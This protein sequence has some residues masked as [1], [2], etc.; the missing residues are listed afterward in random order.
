MDTKHVVLMT[1][2][3]PP[4]P[5]FKEQ[6]VYSW[7]ILLGLTRTV[8]PIPKSLIPLIAL[9]RAHGRRRM[10]RDHGYGSPLEALTRLQAARLQGALE[11]LD[12]EATWSAKVAFEFRLSRLHGHDLR[13]LSLGVLVKQHGAEI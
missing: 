3:E 11:A 12:R 1:Y 13:A 2:G 5:S 7:R 6:L 8:A 4:T 9:A 10:W